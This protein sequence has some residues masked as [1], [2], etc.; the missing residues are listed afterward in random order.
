MLGRL[1][2]ELWSQ[3]LPYAPEVEIR[4][5]DS[6]SY[7]IGKKRNELL[8]AAQGEYVCFID[9]DDSISANYV[10][11]LMKAVESGCDCAS[12]KGEITFDGKNA[13]I[14]EHSRKYLNWKTVHDAEV[15][16]ERFPNHLNLIKASIAKRF[17]FPEK[18]HG[19]DYDWSHKVN[20]SG[21]I[22][23]EFYIPQVIYYYRYVTNKKHE[24]QPK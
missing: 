3:I 9:D 22:Q 20:D 11:L 19:E 18:N 16:Y 12:L 15:T 6:Q 24:L 2:S 17:E 5:H 14:F 1:Q 21:L 10:E 7:S 4:I 13:K 8:Q 23:T